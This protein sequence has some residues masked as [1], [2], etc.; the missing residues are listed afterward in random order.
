MSEWIASPATPNQSYRHYHYHH[1]APITFLSKPTPPHSSIPSSKPPPQHPP[2]PLPIRHPLR[3]HFGMH[4]P[5]QIRLPALPAATLQPAPDV[6]PTLRGEEPGRRAEIDLVG[7]EQ[8]GAHGVDVGGGDGGE[9]GRD[10]R[11]G[12]GVEEV[13]GWHLHV[14]RYKRDVC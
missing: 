5:G 8:Q 7:R 2:R 13:P 6:R 1:R 14:A 11:E 9:F 10:G 3:R 4:A 12:G